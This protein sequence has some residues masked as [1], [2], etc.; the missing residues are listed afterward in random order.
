MSVAVSLAIV[1]SGC[2][3]DSDGEVGG[4]TGSFEVIA[5]QRRADPPGGT[6]IDG[7]QVAVFTSQEEL[8]SAWPDWEP[9]ATDPPSVDGLDTDRSVVLLWARDHPV[10]VTGATMEEGSLV[11]EGTREVPGPG[12]FTTDEVTGWTTV[13]AVQAVPSQPRDPTLD[14]SS[15]TIDC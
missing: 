3:P 2:G 5:T 7:V 9:L 11:I 10:R 14:V 4:G 12:C 15:E 1:I 8:D 6:D 13:V